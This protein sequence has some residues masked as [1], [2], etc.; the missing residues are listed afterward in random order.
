MM[1]T[2]SRR[3]LTSNRFQIA[4]CNYTYL[5]SQIVSKLLIVYHPKVFARILKILY[6]LLL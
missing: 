5:E 1:K 2:A 6:E 4:S 3:V